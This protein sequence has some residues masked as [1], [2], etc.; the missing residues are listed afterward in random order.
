[1]RRVAAV[2]LAVLIAAVL[3]APRAH[4]SGCPARRAVTGRLPGVTP[5]QETLA[6]WLRVT[7]TRHDLDR[8]LLHARDAARQ[9]AVAARFG[10]D[11]GVLLAPPDE[12]AVR[13]QVASLLDLLH[14][15]AARGRWLDASGH[16]LDTSRLPR[17]DAASLVLAPHVRVA[18]ARTLL[19]C[20]PLPRA[21]RDA[22]DADRTDDVNACSAVAPQEAVQTLADGPGTLRLARTRSALGWIAADAPLSPPA[23]AGR[24]RGRA[25]LGDRRVRA[26]IYAAAPGP[27]RGRIEVPAGTLLPLAP[28]RTDRV[29][30]AT[31]DGVAEARRPAGLRAVPRIPTRRAVLTTA[32]AALGQPYG[33]GGAGGIDCSA[34]LQDAFAAAGVA[35]P[36]HSADQARAGVLSVDLRGL[37]PAQRQVRLD[38]ADARGLVLLHLPGHVALYLGRNADGVPMT[39]HALGSYRTPCPD[40]RGETRQVVRRVVVSRLDLG[41]G[42]REGSLLERLDTLAVFGPSTAAPP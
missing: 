14:Q 39:L 19:R 10:A 20:M 37:T 4:A 17:A 23:G 3:T 9:K 36:R 41:A 30:I 11:A 40:G 33:L 2:V 22:G 15:R 31:R 5:A 24:R 28:G 27:P 25:F 18:L 35:L 13:A 12:R 29:L 8:P 21:L 1:M 6:Y 26:A 38:A 34:L 32:F 42:T 7:G 16:P